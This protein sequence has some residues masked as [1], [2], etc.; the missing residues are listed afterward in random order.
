MSFTAYDPR[1]WFWIVGS[2][3]SRVYSSERRNY[4]PA[5]DPL[6]AGFAGAGGYAT[7]IA[8]EDELREVLAQQYPAGW[9]GP[10]APV[11]VIRSLAFRERLPAEK[12]NAVNVAAM[13]AAANG[14]GALMTF[15]L[16]QA[17]STETD[18][19]DPRTQAGVAALLAARLITQ[20]EADAMLADGTPE[21]AP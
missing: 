13:Q 14:D 15:L 4:I 20:A 7:R 17:S 2:D 16:D 21:E 18:L 5:D 3:E 12:R 8:S 11:R 9:G 6:Y 10:A 1:R 19:D